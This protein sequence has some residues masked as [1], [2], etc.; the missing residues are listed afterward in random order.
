MLRAVIY[1][2]DGTLVDSEGAIALAGKEALVG[3]GDRVSA[4]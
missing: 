3:L 2:M 1:D 4:P